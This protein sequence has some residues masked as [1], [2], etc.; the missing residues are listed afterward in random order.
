MRIALT[1]AAAAALW[2]S[3]AMATDWWLVATTASKSSAA[4]IDKDSIDKSDDNLR[5]AQT[6]QVFAK[7]EG[8]AAAMQALIEFDCTGKRYNFI[9]ITAFKPSGEKIDTQDGSRTW[10]TVEPGAVNESQLQFVCSS[11][12]QPEGTVSFGSAMP[13]ARARERLANDKPNTYGGH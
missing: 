11:G 12:A 13:I 3:P 1:L 5:R 4:L 8:A 6:M 2:T 10:R 9:S 7:D